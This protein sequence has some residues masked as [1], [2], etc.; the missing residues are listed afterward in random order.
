MNELQSAILDVY[1]KVAHLCDANNIRY[2]AYA[3]TAI[4]LI[5]HS[6]FIPWDDDLDIAMPL[7]DYLRFIELAKT[8]LPSGYELISFDTHDIYNHFFAK[9]CNSNTLYVVEKYAD[10]PQ[11]YFGVYVDVFPLSGVPNRENDYM[12]MRKKVNFLHVLGNKQKLPFAYATSFKSK[13]LWLLCAPLRLFKN[14]IIYKKWL[15]LVSANHFETSDYISSVG[16]QQIQYPRF[17]RHCFDNTLI[18]QFE[19]TRMPIPE[20]YEELLSATYGNYMEVPPVESRITHNGFVDLDH[21]YKEYQ[22][23]RLSV[24]KS[25]WK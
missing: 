6:G 1:E 13:F 8:E 25:I 5:R 10:L 7:D 16:W 2:Y 20:S 4:G 17:K 3:G 21:S 14:D 23:G 15:K 22:S 12:T 19:H 18:M 9:V 24:D 11:R